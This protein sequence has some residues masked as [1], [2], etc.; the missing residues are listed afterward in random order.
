LKCRQ[1]AA[2]LCPQYAFAIAE[3][4]REGEQLVAVATTRVEVVRRP[5]G[6]HRIVEDPREDPRIAEGTR[7]VDRLIR[8]RRAALDRARVVAEGQREAPLQE[9]THGG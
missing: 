6:P 4:R 3:C 9:D 5:R 1:S 8:Q 7:A 2:P